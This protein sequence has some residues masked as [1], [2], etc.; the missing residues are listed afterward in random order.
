M[1]FA[2]TLQD[3]QVERLSLGLR[4]PRWLISRA[5]VAPSRPKWKQRDEQQAKQHRILIIVCS[6]GGSIIES[7][8]VIKWTGTQT[9]C[10]R[11]HRCPFKLTHKLAQH[12]QHQAILGRRYLCSTR[13]SASRSTW[14]SRSRRI[15]HQPRRNCR[16]RRKWSWN[17]TTNL[18]RRQR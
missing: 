15:H 14:C 7:R 13:T 16:S 8:R 9:T 18:G 2:A 12:V 17:R 3:W 4:V 11:P 10:P 6:S 1:R 5:S